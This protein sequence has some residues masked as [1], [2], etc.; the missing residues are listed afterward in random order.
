MLHEQMKGSYFYKSPSDANSRRRY[1][2]NHSLKSIF[3]YNGNEYEVSQNTTCSC[4]NIYYKMQI[5]ENEQLITK[6]SKY[7]LKRIMSGV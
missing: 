1:E 3:H 6:G 5:Y 4:N 2:Q 7:P